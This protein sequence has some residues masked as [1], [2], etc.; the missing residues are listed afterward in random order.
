MT[1]VRYFRPNASICA[2]EAPPSV[3]L[4]GVVETRADRGLSGPTPSRN[5][6]VLFYQSLPFVTGTLAHKTARALGC[7]RHNPIATTTD[8]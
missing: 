6:P 4:F 8:V 2:G 5:L 7:R 3:E 1:P